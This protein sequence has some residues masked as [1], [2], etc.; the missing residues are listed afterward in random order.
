[1]TE[2]DDLDIPVDVWTADAATP[3]PLAVALLKGRTASPAQEDPR[4]AFLEGLLRQVRER[5]RARA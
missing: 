4:L 1:M 5:R 3:V 2:D